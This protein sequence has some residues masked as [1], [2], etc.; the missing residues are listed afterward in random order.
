MHSFVWRRPNSLSI[1]FKRNQKS[2]GRRV[3]RTDTIRAFISVRSIFLLRQSKRPKTKNTAVKETRTVVVLNC[4]AQKKTSPSAYT[5]FVGSAPTARVTNATVFE[6][7]FCFPVFQF[8]DFEYIT[9]RNSSAPAICLQI[10][11][12]FLFSHIRDGQSEIRTIAFQ[13]RRT[14]VRF[15]YTTRY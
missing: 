1:P 9:R 15:S 13:S 10:I 7:L 4:G 14:L 8:P 5:T 6:K 11:S 3:R 2:V 12:Y